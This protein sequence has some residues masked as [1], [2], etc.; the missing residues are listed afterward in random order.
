[1]EQQAINQAIDLFQIRFGIPPQESRYPVIDIYEKQHAYLYAEAEEAIAA[2]KTHQNIIRWIMC[3]YLWPLAA[4]TILL[5]YAA[6][7]FQNLNILW[8]SAAL[9]FMPAG[10]FCCFSFPIRYS[11]Q[12]RNKKQDN[13]AELL[14]Q[15][16]LSF[17]NGTFN[18]VPFRYSDKPFCSVCLKI[19]K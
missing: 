13:L 6:A 5:F 7:K 18:K 11:K 15:M 4:N 9:F 12:I 3:F 8:S 14:I 17:L 19:Y 16:N 2:Y 10:A 1:M